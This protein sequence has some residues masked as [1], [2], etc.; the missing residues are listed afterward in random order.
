LCSQQDGKPFVLHVPAAVLS[1]RLSEV[2]PTWTV[3]SEVVSKM[4]LLCSK[5]FFKHLVSEEK[6]KKW[7]LQRGEESFSPC[8][9][10]GSPECSQADME[11]QATPFL[12]WVA[13]KAHGLFSSIY[14]GSYSLQNS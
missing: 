5:L 8:R 12:S 11:T 1:Y 3:D 6:K 14:K 7:Q 4:Y 9:F 2:K 10:K 13:L